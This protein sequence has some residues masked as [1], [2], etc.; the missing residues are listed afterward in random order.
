MVCVPAK[1]KLP[2][3]ENLTPLTGAVEILYVPGVVTLTVIVCDTLPKVIGVPTVIDPFTTVLQ[4]KIESI[5]AV[6]PED[7]CVTDLVRVQARPPILIAKLA[8]PKVAGVPV[9]LYVT[10]LS[11]ETKEPAVSVAV[12]PVTPVEVTVCPPC[13]PP[14]PPVYWIVELTP[15]AAELA[16]NIPLSLALAHKMLVIEPPG[17]TVAVALPAG[18]VFV[19]H[20]VDPEAVGV[21]VAVSVIIRQ[22][23]PVKIPDPEKVTPLVGPEVIFQVPTCVTLTW[24]V[25]VTPLTA[26]P[27]VRAPLIILAEQGEPPIDEASAVPPVE[28]LIPEAHCHVGAVGVPIFI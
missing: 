16:D 3:P 24:R 17:A 20:V 7:G 1:G 5:T 21:P 10:I 11:P 12:R 26:I 18:I 14:F 25:M 15:E 4:D 23:V 6:P 13:G 8:V 27:A 19:F 2:L 9:I 28:G 22:P